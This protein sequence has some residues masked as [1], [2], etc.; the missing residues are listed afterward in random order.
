MAAVEEASDE[1]CR[2]DH[3]EEAQSVILGHFVLD[4][5]GGG[6]DGSSIGGGVDAEGVPDLVF[7]VGVE[8]EVGDDAE[9]GAGAFEGTEEIRVGQ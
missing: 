2:Y 5:E 3:K 7:W 4:G 9:V 1:V 8:G 6:H